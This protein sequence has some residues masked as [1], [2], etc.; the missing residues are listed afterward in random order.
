MRINEILNEC[1]RELDDLEI[2]YASGINEVIINSR[3]ST[4]IGRCC[5]S[6]G[7]YTIEV[8]PIVADES[9]NKLAVK[10]VL[11]HELLHSVNGA[12][13]HN[14]TWYRYVYKVNHKYG[15]DIERCGSLASFKVK[16][17][18]KYG[19]K[20]LVECKGCG[21]KY[22]SKQEHKTHKHLECCYCTNCKKYALKLI[23][24]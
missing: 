15:Y 20:F 18:K 19:Y 12:M 5:K 7:K 3:L 11:I 23:I 6:K 17:Y 16:D 24:L 4:T 21:S 8:C 22:Y 14:N 2:P 13:A 10:Q 1:K 9:A